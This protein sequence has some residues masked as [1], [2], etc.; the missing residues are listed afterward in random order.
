MSE[1]YNGKF[2]QNKSE[3]NKKTLKT[4]HFTEP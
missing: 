1:V 2:P 4:H 3:T